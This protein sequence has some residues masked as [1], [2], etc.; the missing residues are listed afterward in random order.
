MHKK[1]KMRKKNV[2][3]LV[4]ILIIAACLAIFFVLKVLPKLTG[5][6][7][8]ESEEATARSSVYAGRLL[9][10]IRKSI[11]IPGR[12]LPTKEKSTDTTTI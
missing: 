7:S 2:F 3:T 1:P 6:A 9:Q 12:R 10:G 5:A 4:M 11:R 8:A